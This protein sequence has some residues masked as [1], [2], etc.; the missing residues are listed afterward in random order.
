[1]G[2]LH[3]HV[4]VHGRV[5]GVG[6]RYMTEMKANEIGVFGYVKNLPDG[7]VET[8]IEG[9]ASKVYQLIDE[10]KSGIS[11][12][13]KVTDVDVEVTEELTGYSRFRTTY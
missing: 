6:F 12:S 13:A 2:K 10:I 8:E 1:M 5:Q 3:A 11:P 9:E 4:I 7:R